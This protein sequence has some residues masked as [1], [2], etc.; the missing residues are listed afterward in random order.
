MRKKIIILFPIVLMIILIIV[1][2]KSEQVYAAN[3][4]SDIGGSPSTT[5]GGGGGGGASST[6]NL[7]FST[8]LKVNLVDVSGTSPA[9]KGSHYYVFTG[10]EGNK[11]TWESYYNYLQNNNKNGNLTVCGK[12]GSGS[13]S[14][15]CESIAGNYTATSSDWFIDSNAQPGQPFQYG[16]INAS[17]TKI[18]NYLTNESRFEE[19]VNS[20]GINSLL[21]KQ[22]DYDTLTDEDKVLLKKYRLIVEPVYAFNRCATCFDY[23][24]ATIKGIATIMKSEAPSGNLSRHMGEFARNIYAS[25]RHGTINKIGTLPAISNEFYTTGTA[26]YNTLSDI[27]SGYGYGI[28]YL[29]EGCD[30]TYECCFDSAGKFHSDYIYEDS[31]TCEGSDSEANCPIEN[32]RACAIDEPEDPTPISCPAE[33]NTGNMINPLTCANEE[34]YTEIKKINLN[35]LGISKTYTS[36]TTKYNEW[37]SYLKQKN[38]NDASSCSTEIKVKVTGE[39]SVEQMG[40]VGFTLSPTSVFAGGGFEFSVEYASNVK[41]TICDPGLTFTASRSYDIY[42]CSPK[43]DYD[44]DYDDDGD[45]YYDRIVE[46]EYN[47][48]TPDASHKCTYT[49][50]TTTYFYEIE[51]IDRTTYESDPW[52]YEY[53]YCVDYDFYYFTNAAGEEDYNLMCYVYDKSELDQEIIPKDTFENNWDYYTED[54]CLTYDYNTYN[55][56]YRCYREVEDDN[57]LPAVDANHT[58]SSDEY[59]SYTCDGDC[60]TSKTGPGFSVEKEIDEVASNMAMYITTPNLNSLHSNIGTTFSKN[61]DVVTSSSSRVKMSGNW[62]ETYIYNGTT[63][64]TINIDKWY[65]NETIKYNANYKLGQA[66]IGLS[67]K[68]ISGEKVKAP[69][70]YDNACNTEQKDGGRNWYVP[71]KEQNNS[72][73]PVQ[74]NIN[75]TYGTS[76]SKNMNWPLNYT[77]SVNVEQKLYNNEGKYV[78]M[79]RPISLSKPFPNR[80]EGINWTNLR[81]NN[82]TVFEQKITNGRNDTELEYHIKLTP[83]LISQLKNETK[84]YNDLS[85]INLDGSSKILNGLSGLTRNGTHNRIGYCDN[86]CW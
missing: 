58:C 85:T 78:F 69:I 62:E 47:S 86:N 33:S 22:F 56:E 30:P 52:Y 5:I 82:S 41:Y 79:Y 50:Y 16:G 23:T 54:Y 19:I 68:N 39:V 73:F 42:S 7:T 24:F 4:I 25:N 6:Y 43:D 27:N 65:S 3:I 10:Y 70:D 84:A 28:F 51:P 34:R 46:Y 21:G 67:P 44:D 77:C 1:A 12:I 9:L 20:T 55:N 81:D 76:L 40:K 64:D 32:L 11:N 36:G 2:S 59:A 53:D 83:T 37:E 35:G 66:C 45:G 61:S 15:A 49:E 74:V 29:V 57:T 31:Y 13:Y 80:Q 48:P 72:N 75:S 18:K 14:S 17:Q 60:L 8:I 26:Y 63:S 38:S 71:L